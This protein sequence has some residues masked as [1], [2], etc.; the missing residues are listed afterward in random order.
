M[1]L[2][3]LNK[4]L[5]DQVNDNP[6]SSTK[7][8]DKSTT[9]Q[10]EE[11]K[12]KVNNSIQINIITKVIAKT[13][14]CKDLFMGASID[15]NKQITKFI[16]EQSKEMASGSLI[17]NV[18]ESSNQK[19]RIENPTNHLSN[20][21]YSIEEGG[22]EYESHSKVA[23]TAEYAPWV[24]WGT[25]LHGELSPSHYIYPVKAKYMTWINKNGEQIFALRTQGQYPKPFMRGAIYKLK[26][27]ISK[28]IRI[29]IK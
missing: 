5:H 7:M 12:K 17:F 27:M 1:S 8:W 14:L 4:G 22:S 16:E 6:Q 20:S 11:I 3:K 21:I 23:T 13:P 29:D 9:Q 19:N 10:I 28:I 2:S 18:P 15:V 26:A 24:E 25:G